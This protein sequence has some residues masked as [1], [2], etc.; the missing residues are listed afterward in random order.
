MEDMLQDVEGMWIGRFEEREGVKYIRKWYSIKSINARRK[1]RCNGSKEFTI[2][3]HGHPRGHRFIC[4]SNRGGTALERLP[5]TIRS[6][7]KDCLSFEWKNQLRC[8]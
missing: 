3:K 6:C 7:K 2:L 1:Y 5:R 8:V 4:L